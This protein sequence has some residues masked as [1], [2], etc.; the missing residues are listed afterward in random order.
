[1]LLE[2]TGIS[3]RYGAVR[4]LDE[5]SLGVAQGEIAALMGPQAGR[6]SPRC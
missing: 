6:A 4:A 5:V 1:M 3:V 2:L